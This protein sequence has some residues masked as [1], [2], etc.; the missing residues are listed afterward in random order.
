MHRYIIKRLFMLIPVILGISLIIFSIVSLSPGNPGRLSLGV[1]ASEE[2]VEQ[3]NRK[4]G[5]YDPFI[6]KYKNYLVNAIQGDFGQSYRTGESVFSMI[7]VRLPTTMKLAMFAITIA[8][9]FGIPIG[10]LS[11]VKQYSF[12]DAASMVA[13]LLL[14]SIPGFWL[15]LILIL[16]FSLKL[17][18]FPVTG[19]DTPLHY[20]LPSITI[21]APSLAV[22]IRV[23]R[24]TMLEVIRQD[25]VRTARSKGSG[26]LKIILKHCLR[27]A[28]IPVVTIIGM[29]FGYLLGGTI[30]A[31]TL[32]GMPGVGELMVKAIRM[33]DLPVIMASVI[34]LA[35]I[36]CILNLV[37]DIIYSFIDPRIK[38]SYKT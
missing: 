37:I 7:A 31:E 18:I 8:A 23:T 5:Y 14:A 27:N 10:I 26:E 21:A 33:K 6:V 9:V 3:L 20:V 11:A 30:I 16:T 35:A 17:G 2:A 38:A 29:D 13:A 24:S 28:M 19:S 22:I 32:F 25:Y 15:G 36:F 12:I 4:L 1:N 34:L